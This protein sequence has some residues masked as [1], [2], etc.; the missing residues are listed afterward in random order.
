MMRRRRFYL[1]SIHV[2]DE[3]HET[4]VRSLSCLECGRTV[5]T[6]TTKRRLYGL[7]ARIALWWHE[8][9]ECVGRSGG[10]RYT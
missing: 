10:G 1:P 7:R 8:H 3:L 6:A 4:G 5:V 9:F 2:L